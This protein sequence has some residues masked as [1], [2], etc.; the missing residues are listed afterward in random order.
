MK[1][2]RAF[3]KVKDW[4]E[5][6]EPEFFDAFAKQTDIKSKRKIQKKHK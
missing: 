1:A 5:A 6:N 4:V 3:Y 2:V